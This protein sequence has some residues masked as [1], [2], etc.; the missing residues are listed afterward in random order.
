MA[1]RWA[2]ARGWIRGP[3]NRAAGTRP[4][5]SARA[6]GGTAHCSSSTGLSWSG[7][8]GGAG[9]WA[10]GSMGGDDEIGRREHGR[11]RAH[12]HADW[13]D[14]AGRRRPVIDGVGHSRSTTR[15]H[16]RVVCG[17]G[18]DPTLRTAGRYK[19]ANCA[20]AQPVFY[21]FG[22]LTHGKVISVSVLSG[23]WRSQETDVFCT[24]VAG[25]IDD[26]GV[27][28]TTA[29]GSAPTAPGAA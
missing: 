4:P 3:L 10:P 24:D 16:Q 22:R 26:D 27:V 17:R 14:S 5:A 11:R 29:T 18:R 8:S 15:R 19:V 7:S 25:L 23:C 1:G 2:G 9:R 6:P 21:R 28:S 20:R 13:P 12:G